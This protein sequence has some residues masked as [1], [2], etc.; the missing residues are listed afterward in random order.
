MTRPIH[1]A[2]LCPPDDMH[3]NRAAAIGV[4][5]V[6]LRIGPGFPITADEFRPQEVSQ[7][8]TALAARHLEARAIGFY[9]NHLHPDVAVRELELRRLR[10]VFR[11]AEELGIRL[12]GVF[13]G[14]DPEKTVEDNLPVFIETWGPVAEEAERRGLRIAFEN[15][16]MYRGYPVRGINIA[17]CPHA[18]SLMFEALPSPALGI[19]FDPSHLLKQQIDIGKVVHQFGHRIFHVHLKDHEV[20]RDAIQRFGCFDPRCSRDRLPGRGQIDFAALLHQLAAFG[21]QGHFT[22]EGE[23]DPEDVTESSPVPSLAESVKFIRSIHMPSRTDVR[24]LR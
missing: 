7:L 24:I 3:L 14:R 12:I 23:R 9:R 1:L 2:W 4:D 20:D 6:Q 22:I 19:E 10:N 5:G 16:T 18:L 15:C 11:L 13:A 17:Y 21:Y 8:K